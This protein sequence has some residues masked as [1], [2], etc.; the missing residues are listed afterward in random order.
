MDLIWIDL[1][2]TGLDAKVD[3]IIEAAVIIT[4]PQLEPLAHHHFIIDPPIEAAAHMDARDDDFVRRRVG[5]S[6]ERWRDLRARPF[7]D[8]A[9]DLVALLKGRRLAG[10][11]TH[12][13]RDF[14]TAE[15]DRVGVTLS[16]VLGTFR[17][18]DLASLAYPLV[19]G[20]WIGESA[21]WRICTALDVEYDS[22]R[23]HSAYYDIRLTLECARRLVRP[24]LAEGD[25][26]DFSTGAPLWVLTDIE[27]QA[28]EIT[29]RTREGIKLIRA[30]NEIMGALKARAE[31]MNKD[32]VAK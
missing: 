29:R 2:T 32:E 26:V 1:E 12:F 10:H 9:D 24:Q 20:G 19:A 15:L 22:D 27:R 13:E 16:R 7:A 21:L 8:V 5:Y 28:A 31:I 3:A 25:R 14:L 17:L 11:V 4:T 23:A 18:L 6:E 30:Q